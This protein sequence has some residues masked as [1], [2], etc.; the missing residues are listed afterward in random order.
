MARLLSQ[1]LTRVSKN[2]ALTPSPFSLLSRRTRSSFPENLELIEIEVERDPSSAAVAAEV[3]VLGMRLLEEAIHGI[4]V[5]RSAPDW[6]PFVPGA[7]YWVPP[8]RRPLGFA[9]LV[10]RMANPMTEEEELA[11]TTVRGWPSASYF[12]EGG[13]PHPVKRRPK[14]VTAQTDDEES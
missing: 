10:S 3:E 8:R 2:L 5:R 13:S 1:T 4:I 12:L 9:E 7:S 11:F 14:K 6:L